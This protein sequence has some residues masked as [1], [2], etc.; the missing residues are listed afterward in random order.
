MTN[1]TQKISPRVYI[2]LANTISKDASRYYLHG[3]HLCEGEGRATIAVSTDGH[4]LS[5]YTMADIPFEL[6]ADAIAKVTPDALRAAKAM[7]KSSAKTDIELSENGDMR[8]G[9]VTY[10]NMLIDAAFPNWR[11][12]V[13]DTINPTDAA[14]VNID[15]D[16]I[17]QFAKVSKA[18]GEP[19]PA[20]SM[21]ANSKNDPIGVKLSDPQ[22]IGVLM[23]YKVDEWTW[24]GAPSAP[25][26][27]AA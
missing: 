26:D 23:P 9:D 4:V 17:A 22:Y 3:I 15:A 25:V 16:K 24:N 2:A 1:T 12:V 11:R 8:F 20:I 5:A 14:P 27:N 10:H 21:L 7:L 19:T 18:L 13:P 6:G